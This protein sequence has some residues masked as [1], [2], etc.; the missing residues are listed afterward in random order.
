MRADCAAPEGVTHE[1]PVGNEKGLL[2]VGVPLVLIV[3]VALLDL[4]PKI[5]LGTMGAMSVLSFLTYGIDK[6]KAV[7]G[8]WRT[9]EDTLHLIDLCG[10]W[11]GGALAQIFFRHKVSKASFRGVYWTTVAVS[12]AALVAVSTAINMG[13]IPE[14]SWD[15]VQR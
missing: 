2:W 4:I 9:S 13:F 15:D 3:S 7:S 6:L 10:G 1:T 8:G 5:C 11:P 12:I 14:P